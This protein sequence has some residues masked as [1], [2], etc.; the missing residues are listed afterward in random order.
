MIRMTFTFDERTVE[1][2]RRAA[3]RSR[4][5]QSAVVR[6]AI[7]DYADR[8]G[9]LSDEERRHLLHVVDRMMARPATRRQKAT[10]DEIAAIRAARRTAGR[11]T[12]AE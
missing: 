5:P 7:R 2:L 3:A 9:R 12:R 6:E 4:K 10:D 11:R 8:M 1:T